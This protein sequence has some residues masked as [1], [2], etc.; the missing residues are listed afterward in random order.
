MPPGATEGLSYY[1]PLEQARQFLQRPIFLTFTRSGYPV[2]NPNNRPMYY[3][4]WFWFQVTGRAACIIRSRKKETSRA[5]ALL[6]R[7]EKTH[8]GRFNPATGRKI[9]VSYG[10]Y[11]PMICD[12]FAGLHGR[13]TTEEEKDRYIHYFICSSLF[14]DFTDYELITEQRLR[15]ISFNPAHEPKGF[16]EK[17]FLGAHRL[18]R[19]FVRQKDA[20]DELSRRLF[21][22]QLESKKQYH[23]TLDAE[24]LRSVTFRKGGYSVLLCRFYLDA[25]A[26]T[27]EEDCWY[28]IGTLIQLT[29]DLYDIHK[30]LTDQI[31]TPANSMTD[32][33]AFESFFKKQIGLMK[34]A[35]KKLPYPPKRLRAF[36]L[37]MAGIYAFGLIALHQLKKIQDGRGTLPDLHALD[38]KALVVDM[39]KISNLALWFRFTYHYAR[40]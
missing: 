21:T 7:I 19:D 32:A 40:L 39:E 14:D 18:L 2:E 12:A 24:E 10:I 22:A 5:A 35:I 9:A 26:G 33:Y 13:R 37:Q 4:F 36:S 3:F 31:A 25:E 28:T 8:D 11:N 17:V 38:R 30:D 15:S 23:N 34:D 1:K 27:A 29:N 16:D 6:E 20:Y